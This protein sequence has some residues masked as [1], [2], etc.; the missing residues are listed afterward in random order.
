MFVNQNQMLDVRYEEQKLVLEVIQLGR[1]LDRRGI[2]IIAISER[3]TNDV[4][5]PLHQLGKDGITLGLVHS[6]CSGRDTKYG[7]L[8]SLGH[9]PADTLGSSGGIPLDS[10]APAEDRRSVRQAKDGLETDPKSSNVRSAP[11]RAQPRV[12][13]G[14]DTFLAQRLAVVSAVQA[15]RC[16]SDFDSSSNPASVRARNLVGGV[17]DKLDEL[18]P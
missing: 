9:N 18:S 10:A 13:K 2:V 12:H 4:L 15:V 6:V 14:G 11:F 5:G 16:E 1:Q 7:E 17:L 8:V 3:Q